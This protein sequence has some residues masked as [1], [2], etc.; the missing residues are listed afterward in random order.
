MRDRCY[1]NQQEIQPVIPVSMAQFLY[2]RAQAFSTELELVRFLQNR[3]NW[4][5]DIIR[6]NDAKTLKIIL[7]IA[8]RQLKPLLGIFPHTML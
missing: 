5:I 7:L 6:S 4:E 2:A 3:K 8:Y 1:R